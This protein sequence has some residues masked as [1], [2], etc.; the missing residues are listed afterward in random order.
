MDV[1]LNRD[2]KDGGFDLTGDSLMWK[3]TEIVLFRNP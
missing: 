2:V 3:V 1:N